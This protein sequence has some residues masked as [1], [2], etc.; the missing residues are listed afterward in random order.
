VGTRWEILDTGITV[1]LYP[2]CAATH[3]M[4]DVLLELRREQRFT[5]DDV[6]AIS[7]GVDAITPTVLIHD[8]PANGLQAK[9]SMPY[10]AAA[11]LVHGC[12]GIETFDDERVRQPEIEVVRSRVTMCVD[13]T[14]DTGAPLTQARVRIQLRE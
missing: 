3:P 12:V 10:C 6:A 14:L 5:A 4:L 13:P 1:K 2:S 11:A 7:V 9:F 8:R